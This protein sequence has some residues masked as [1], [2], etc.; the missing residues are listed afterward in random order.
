MKHHIDLGGAIKMAK[1]KSQRVEADNVCWYEIEIKNYAVFKEVFQFIVDHRLDVTVW[2][3]TDDQPRAQP[4]PKT[5][6]RA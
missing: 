1:R 6:G 3:V 2:E 5:V 4:F